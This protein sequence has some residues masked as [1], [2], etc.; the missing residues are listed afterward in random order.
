MEHAVTSC[1]KTNKPVNSG[2]S[3]ENQGTGLQLTGRALH[4]LVVDDNRDAADSLCMLLRLWGYDCR[5]AYDG[6]AGL[7]AACDYRPDCLLIDIAMPGL[8]GYTLARRVRTQPGLDRAKLVALT[9]FSDETHVRRS[10]EAGFHFHLVKPTEPLEIERLMNMLNELIRLA[11][12]AEELARQNV[13]LASE[14]KE[15]LKEVKEDI[16]EVKEEVKELKT[17]K[18]DIKEIKEDVK[19]LKEEL[20]EVKEVRAEEHPENGNFEEPGSQAVD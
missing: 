11:S 4:V 6:A 9:A 1:V 18:E 12:G 2:W 10:Q 20:R 16:E 7:Q 15:L 19:D 3:L 5:V 17:V 8:D 14:T 13:A